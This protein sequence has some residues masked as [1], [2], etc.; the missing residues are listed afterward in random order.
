MV[1]NHI[2][3]RNL[4]NCAMEFLLQQTL[5]H[6]YILVQLSFIQKF[7]INLN[8]DV[9]IFILF[10][11]RHS[12]LIFVKNLYQSNNDPNKLH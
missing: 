1:K 4:R 8:M 3:K 10:N 7:L 5:I 12:M 11:N 9:K 6:F 2:Q